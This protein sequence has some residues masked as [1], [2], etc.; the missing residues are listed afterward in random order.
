MKLGF[1]NE[2]S[3]IFGPGVGH[4]CS[5]NVGICVAVGAKVFVEDA[6]NHLS[7]DPVFVVVEIEDQSIFQTVILI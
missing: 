7:G 2:V 5:F 6:A 4:N 1:S 3:Y